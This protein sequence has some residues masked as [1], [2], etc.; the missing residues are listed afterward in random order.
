[1][2]SSP[3]Q[4]PVNTSFRSWVH[5]TLDARG[6]EDHDTYLCDLVAAGVRDTDSTVPAQAYGKRRLPAN[7]GPQF[8]Q[9]LGIP[10]TAYPAFLAYE[11]GE[12]VARHHFQDFGVAFVAK[13]SDQPWLDQIGA[14]LEWEI[15]ST[16]LRKWKGARAPSRS[17]SISPIIY[18]ELTRTVRRELQFS[19]SFCRRTASCLS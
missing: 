5:A 14:Q 15:D 17:M 3:W 6:I 1:M 2:S 9:A 10:D 18:G 7:W 11:F 4:R 16:D 13:L 19:S 8:A 12:S